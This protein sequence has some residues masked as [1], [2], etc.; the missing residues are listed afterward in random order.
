MKAWWLFKNESRDRHQEA[1][2]SLVRFAAIAFVAA[3]VITAIGEASRTDDANRDVAPAAMTHDPLAADLSRCRDVTAEKMA[4]DDTCRRVWA[5][6]RRRFFAPSNKP[7]EA[8]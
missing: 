4:S 2:K 3:V 8:R 7:G 6:N 5:E 1:V